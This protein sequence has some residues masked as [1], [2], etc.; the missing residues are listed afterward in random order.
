M[1]FEKY[2]FYLLVLVHLLPAILL[3]Y[4]V[5]HDGPAHVYNA[6]LIHRMIFDQDPGGSV[7]FHFNPQI[8]PN[9][10]SHILLGLFNLVMDA[11]LSERLLVAIYFVT[12]PLAF[13]ALVF[14]VKP[15]A[16]AGSC[17]VFQYLQSFSVLT[18]LYSFC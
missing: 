14:A 15:V 17:L 13:L 9:W 5:T 12:F 2:F 7:F 3:P 11:A 18:S 10:I 6:N 4:F 8:L 16:F 1:K